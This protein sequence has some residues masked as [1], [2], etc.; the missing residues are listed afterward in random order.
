MVEREPAFTPTTPTGLS[1]HGEQPHRHPLRDLHDLVVETSSR[2]KNAPEVTQVVMRVDPVE[3]LVRSSRHAELLV[4]GAH[5]PG[6]AAGVLLGNVLSDCL[7][8]SSCPVVVI[9][10]GSVR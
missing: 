7:R 6:G 1:P 4:L 2:L 8:R 9:P 3:E 5:G 10:P